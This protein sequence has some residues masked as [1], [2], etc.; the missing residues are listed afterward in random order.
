RFYTV[1]EEGT[2]TLLP[3]DERGNQDDALGG[4]AFYLG[5]AELEIPLASIASELGMLPSIFV[6]AGA[7]FGIRRA[8]LTVRPYPDGIFIPTRDADGNALY[9][10]INEATLVDGTCRPGTGSG[11]I[12]I[13]TSPT[14]PNPPSCL[15]SNANTAIA[16]SLPPFVEEFYGNT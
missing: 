11:A 13:V 1:D 8:V 7:V 5:R 16:N 14:N 3:L 9:T 15:T 10:Q 12:S 4:A 2:A 6:D